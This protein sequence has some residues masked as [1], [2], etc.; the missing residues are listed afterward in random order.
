MAFR[1]DHRPSSHNTHANCWKEKRPEP[2]S[3]SPDILYKMSKK[4]AQLTKVIYTLNTRLDDQDVL[5][6]SLKEAHEERIQQLMTETRYRISYYKA[7]ANHEGELRG[8]VKELETLLKE[9]KCKKADVEEQ[10][11]LL[12]EKQL[13]REQEEGE[14]SQKLARLS[15]EFEDAKN[16]LQVKLKEYEILHQELLREKD[17]SLG[18]L[19]NQYEKDMQNI[20]HDQNKHFESVNNNIVSELDKAYENIKDLKDQCEQLKFENVQIKQDFELELTKQLDDLQSEK[21][22]LKCYFESNIKKLKSYYQEE[23]GKLSK[24]ENLIKTQSFVKWE[25]E[26][27]DK[28]KQLESGIDELLHKLEENEKQTENYIAENNQLKEKIESKV[29]HIKL[30][31]DQMTKSKEELLK[32]TPRLKHSEAALNQLKNSCTT[33]TQDLLA[34]THHISLLEATKLEHETTILNLKEDIALLKEKFQKLE[35]LKSE[36]ETSAKQKEAELLRNMSNLKKDL[37]ELQESKSRLQEQFEQQSIALKCQNSERDEA[38]QDTYEKQLQELREQ[39]RSQIV[40][41]NDQWE[42]KMKNK[43]EEF[44]N[45]LEDKRQKLESQQQEY[46]TSIASLEK[47]LKDKSQ[48]ES[49]KITSLHMALDEKN[50]NLNS[51]QKLVTSLSLQ[52]TQLEEDL[53]TTKS[54]LKEMKENLHKTQKLWDE[55]KD[56]IQEEYIQQQKQLTSSLNTSWQ[57]K[58]RKELDQMKEEIT[59]Q[60]TAALEEANTRKTMEFEASKRGWQSKITELMEQM[61]R[62]RKMSE[63]TEEKHLK[64]VYEI[65]T[66]AQSE[67][68]K[69]QKALKELEEDYKE[70]IITLECSYSDR[71]QTKLQEKES[72]DREE[73]KQLETRHQKEL[74]AQGEAHRIE[75]EQVKLESE[76]FWNEERERLQ[77]KHAIHIG[78]IR[79]ELQVEKKQALDKQAQTHRAEVRRA[80]MELD[81]CLREVHQKEETSALKERH[82]NREQEEQRSQISQLKTEINSLQDRLELKNR[83]LEQ[84]QEEITRVRNETGHQLRNVENYWQER[85]VQEL[86]K[87]AM[88]YEQHQKTMLTDFN[89][90]QRLL[91]D[92]IRLLQKMLQEAEQRYAARNSRPEDLEVIRQLQK[93]LTDK[94]ASMS[95]LQEE[96]KNLRLE[97][98]N[99]ET[100]FNRMFSSQPVVGVLDPLASLKKRKPPIDHVVVKHVSSPLLS[101]RIS[102][103]CS[104]NVNENW[105]SNSQSPNGVSEGSQ[106]SSNCRTNQSLPTRPKLRTIGQRASWAGENLHKSYVCNSSEPLNLSYDPADLKTTSCINLT[107]DSYSCDQVTVALNDRPVT[108]LMNSQ[109]LHRSSSPLF[110]S[111]SHLVCGTIDECDEGTSPVEVKGESH[112][113]LTHHQQNK[114]SV[115][116]SSTFMD[117]VSLT[118]SQL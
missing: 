64:E 44:D 28:Q 76:H 63:E 33:H 14:T 47:Q 49:E 5:I 58:M 34:K 11:H 62:L 118:E 1:W 25:Q 115:T 23:L 80:R 27:L 75:I 55:E 70:R 67:C 83:E 89:K 94:E 36:C 110:S 3:M 53:A 42:H 84:K 60:G 29:K 74:E 46:E 56:T 17:S 4:I 116:S 91:K 8:K 22:E 10:L 39:H 104:S 2:S 68:S 107:Q 71:L 32:L 40:T 99:R 57:E 18:M 65:K 9:E 7:K 21:E 61:T 72:F 54:E 106:Y 26:T 77:K 87:T 48:Q 105:N 45:Q 108:S 111:C 81:A 20:V 19:H 43:T 79:E 113:L 52:V 16:D 102:T 96:K 66:E 51:A 37:G 13:A 50:K 82:L 97:L 12:E 86:G 117:K 93:S 90:A 78:L 109:T 6:Q 112:N 114:C 31:E 103:S 100:N 30:L 101:R 15:Q 92:K 38:V 59:S 69:L 24:E 35:K 85:F 73:K 88:E 95:K 41:V 98:L